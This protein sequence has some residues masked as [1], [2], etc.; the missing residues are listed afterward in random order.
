MQKKNIRR[1]TAEEYLKEKINKEKINIIIRDPCIPI[2]YES[3]EDDGPLS[4]PS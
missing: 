2:G 1:I 3:L 4:S